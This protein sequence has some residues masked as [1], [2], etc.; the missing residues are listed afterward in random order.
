MLCDDM[1]GRGMGTNGTGSWDKKIEKSVEA[2]IVKY[3]I[4]NGEDKQIVEGLI[5][6]HGRIVHEDGPECIKS[7]NYCVKEI[8]VPRVVGR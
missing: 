8:F 6:P 3:K 2:P 7:F 4:V 5:H 1:N